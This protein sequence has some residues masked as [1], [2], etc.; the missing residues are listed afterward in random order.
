MKRSGR[1]RAQGKD[2]K[3]ERGGQLQLRRAATDD[4]GKRPTVGP[5]RRWRS[6]PRGSVTANDSAEWRGTKERVVARDAQILAIYLH[7]CDL[8]SIDPFRF[9]DPFSSFVRYQQ[10]IIKITFVKNIKKIYYIK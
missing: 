3:T 5:G 7:H 8:C 2:E 10:I 1:A 9:V 4:E 6:R